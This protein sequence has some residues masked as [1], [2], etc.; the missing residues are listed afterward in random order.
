MAKLRGIVAKRP[1]RRAR[2]ADWPGGGG[3]PGR[4]QPPSQLRAFAAKG[5]SDG[6]RRWRKGI[7]HATV[8]RGAER[9]FAL[10]S[11]AEALAEQQRESRSVAGNGSKGV[12][13]AAP[14]PAPGANAAPGG[15]TRA[16]AVTGRPAP[17]NRAGGAPGGAARADQRRGDE[18]CERRQARAGSPRSHA[19]GRRA[20]HPRGELLL[21]GSG[22]L[23]RKGL[24]VGALFKRRRRRRG[25]APRF[26]AQHALALAR[27]RAGRRRARTAAAR[28]GQPRAVRTP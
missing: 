6:A 17:G 12:A 1:L 4:D 11:A 24:F 2:G 3:S 9:A 28:A 27:Q 5:L 16:R 7:F 22:G 20:A 21:N 23:R 19:R 15:T 14:G 10:A 25:M 26:A 13:A 8:G 18:S